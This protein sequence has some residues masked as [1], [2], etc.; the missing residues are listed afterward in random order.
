VHEDRCQANQKDNL[1]ETG[2][3]GCLR[4]S[5]RPSAHRVISLLKGTALSLH[6]KDGLG[7]IQL[8]VSDSSR[9][10]TA[11]ANDVAA[12]GDFVT[13]YDC[14][15]RKMIFAI[16]VAAG[17]FRTVGDTRGSASLNSKWEP[18]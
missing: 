5:S 16:C 15:Q 6:P 18:G 4:D 17:E 8:S 3:I 2:S 1:P 11:S 7:G 9:V 10:L 12:R 14:N 13:G